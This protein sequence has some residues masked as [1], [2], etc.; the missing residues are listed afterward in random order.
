MAVT[1]DAGLG[2]L[3]LEVEVPSRFSAVFAFGDFHLISQAIT[4]VRQVLAD[5][6]PAK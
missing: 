3:F 5:C 6:H 4:I 1:R 2:F